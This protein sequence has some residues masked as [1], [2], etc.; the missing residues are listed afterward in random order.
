MAGANPRTCIV[1]GH[2]LPVAELIRF[3]ASPDGTV[4][5]D[6]YRKL[7]GRGVWV[8]ARAPVLSE[9]LRKQLFARGFKRNVRAPDSLVLDVDA[10]LDKSA[11][12]ALSLARKA[13]LV[14]T[15]FRQVD[16]AIRTGKAMLILHALDAADD[17]VTKLDQALHAAR[18][19]G[20]TPAATKQIWHSRQLDLALG[21]HNVIHAAAIRGGAARALIG[22]IEALERFRS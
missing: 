6:L 21:G 18:R 9:A 13:G 8:T 1:T 2:T 16:S 4:V 17:G 15:G 3:A 12:N 14:A 19:A 7:P 5:A 11:L 20:F 22:R 10:L